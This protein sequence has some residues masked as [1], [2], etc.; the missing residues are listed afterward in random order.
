MLCSLSFILLWIPCHTDVICL[1][2]HTR[3]H[4]CTCTVLNFLFSPVV[5]VEK[6]KY[7][8]TRV[9]SV[10]QETLVWLISCILLLFIVILLALFVSDSIS[11]PC[12]RGVACCSRH[13][14][15]A[16]LWCV[17]T[18]TTTTTTQ[19]RAPQFFD[20]N[21]GLSAD[22]QSTHAST[23]ASANASAS[24]NARQPLLAYP[25]LLFFFSILVSF[26]SSLFCSYVL[27]PCF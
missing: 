1:F 10:W 23:I 18:T 9:Y 13:V 17:N 24:A 5:E 20:L 2:S 19:H 7:S 25:R 14:T 6:N 22:H 8:C 27:V 26:L 4:I 15:T 16:A 21:G 12:V 11:A 3:T